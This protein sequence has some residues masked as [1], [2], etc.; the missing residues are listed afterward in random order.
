MFFT[1]SNAICR[2]SEGRCGKT[3]ATTTNNKEIHFNF[4]YVLE[5]VL[6]L[7]L[8]KISSFLL[9]SSSFPPVSFLLQLMLLEVRY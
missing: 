5:N 4:S 1:K 3:H 7:H 9:L 2:M 6:R 8:E